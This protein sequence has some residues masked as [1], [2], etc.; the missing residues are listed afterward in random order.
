MLLFPGISNDEIS[1]LRLSKNIGD[2]S[3][4]TYSMSSTTSIDPVSTTVM[5]S[6]N[7]VYSFRAWSSLRISPSVTLQNVVYGPACSIPENV[8]S[9][10]PDLNLAD[11][12]ANRRPPRPTRTHSAEKLPPLLSGMESSEKVMRAALLNIW[13]GFNRG[14]TIARNHLNTRVAI[15]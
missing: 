10:E 13:G 7:E 3:R 6:F 15:Q 11:D 4:W 9:M 2:S 8:A 5:D 1:L 14:V 12:D